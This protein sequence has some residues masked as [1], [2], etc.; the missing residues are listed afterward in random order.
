MGRREG[1]DK[2]SGALKVRGNFKSLTSIGCAALLAAA[3]AAR[4]DSAL[5][6]GI[7]NADMDTTARPQDD[8]F[9]FANGTWLRTVPIP[10]DRSRYGV[11]SLMS[12]RSLIQQRELIEAAQHST[13]PQARKVGDLYASYM[14][15]ARIEHEGAKPIQ[16]ELKRITAITQR[17]ELGSMLA[18]LDRI[19]IVS[20]IGTSVQPDAKHSTQYAFWLSQSGLGLPDREY[21]LSADAHLVEFRTK[22]RQHI[23]KMLALLGDQDTGTQAAAII[24]LETAMAK[25]QWTRVANRDPQK[26]YNPQTVAQL[27]QLAPHIDWTRYFGEV[28]ISANLPTLIVRQPDYLQGLSGLIQSTPLSTWKAYLRFRLLSGRAPYLSHAFVDEDF[29]F[30]QG[31]LRGTPRIQERWKRGCRLVDRFIGSQTRSA[32]GADRSQ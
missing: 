2:A 12:E 21:Y 10:P 32:G 25:I 1:Q 13:D 9:Q 3:A 15:E 18:H 26:T 29:A 22:Y 17:A 7:Q 28:G 19:G 20:P 14:D 23:E 4:A 5:I 30:N 16:S 8:L 31:I 24:A 11:D 27:S 6:S